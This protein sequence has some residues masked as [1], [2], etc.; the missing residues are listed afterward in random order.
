M[1]EASGERRGMVDISS[2]WRVASGDG[3]GHVTS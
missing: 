2:E 3:H 1:M